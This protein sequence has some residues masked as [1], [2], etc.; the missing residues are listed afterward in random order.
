MALVTQARFPKRGKLLEFSLA[1][2]VIGIAGYFLLA[3]LWRVQAEA[4]RTMVESTIRN[5]N[6]AVRMAQ[7]QLIIQGRESEVPG[8]FAGSPARW[9]EAPL[10]GYIEVEREGDVTHTAGGWVWV[11]QTGVLY[12][13]PRHHEALGVAG[14]GAVAWRWTTGSSALAA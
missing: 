5:V 1:V 11:R 4:E 8:L 3:A 12:Y 13:S 2:V 6:S 9:L 14:G 7:A 10:P